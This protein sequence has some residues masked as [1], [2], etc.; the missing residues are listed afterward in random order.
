[1]FSKA[2]TRG[3]KRR[4][5]ESPASPGKG[6]GKGSEESLFQPAHEI[7]WSRIMEVRSWNLSAKHKIWKSMR[8]FWQKKRGKV[9]GISQKVWGRQGSRGHISEKNLCTCSD[10][11]SEVRQSLKLS[12]TEDEIPSEWELWKAWSGGRRQ[13]SYEYIITAVMATRFETCT[14]NWKPSTTTI[15]VS[16]LRFFVSL[17]NLCGKVDRED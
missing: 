17:L 1:M 12:I 13:Q 4:S 6:G 10:D 11:T 7:S 3:M 5:P 2:H 15:I 8:A 14:A 9:K 16:L